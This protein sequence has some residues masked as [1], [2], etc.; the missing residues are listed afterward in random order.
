MYAYNEIT[1][2]KF[3][4]VEGEPYEVLDARIFR[5]QQRKPVNQTRLRNLVTGKVTEYTF[6]QQDKI[7]EADL[8]KRNAKYLYTNRGEWWFCEPDDPSKRFTLPSESV[9]EGGKFLK[10]NSL[11]ELLVFTSPEDEDEKGKIIGVKLPIK[12]ELKVVEA[13][14]GVKGDTAKGGLKQVKLETGATINAPL[15]VNEGE[16][17]RVNTETGEYVERVN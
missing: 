12:V 11:V 5:M 15:F 7:D 17:I 14:P 4:V 9:G 10:G 13:P 2:K 1:P 16:M 3:I 6:H 8:K